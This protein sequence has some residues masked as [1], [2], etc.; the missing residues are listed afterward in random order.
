MVLAVNID[1]FSRTIQ[2]GGPSTQWWVQLASAIVFG[3]AFATMLTL[4]VTP[5]ALM[6]R[7][8]VGRWWRQ[9]LR[10]DRHQ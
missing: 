10:P 8:N 7:V 6:L 2:V 4:I 9:H 3:L 1:F 5:S